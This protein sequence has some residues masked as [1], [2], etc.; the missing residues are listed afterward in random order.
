L[1]EDGSAFAKARYDAY[2]AEMEAYAETLGIDVYETPESPATTEHF[3]RCLDACLTAW[4]K[5]P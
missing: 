5:E 3:F 2:L 1:T 4:R